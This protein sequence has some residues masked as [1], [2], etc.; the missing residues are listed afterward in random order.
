MDIFR[1]TI[2]ISIAGMGLTFA[3][4][5]FLVLAMIALTRWA[6]GTGDVVPGKS[7]PGGAIPTDARLQEEELAAAVAVSV[8]LGLVGRRVHPTHAWHSAQ[9]EEEPSAWQS[10]SRGQQLEQRKTHQT[11]RW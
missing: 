8:A 11:L 7:E 2:N 3:A 4:I 1:Q 10:Y 6:R 5:G 9:S